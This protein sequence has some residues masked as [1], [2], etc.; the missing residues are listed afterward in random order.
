VLFQHN[1]ESETWR[2]HASTNTSLIKRK[3]FELEFRKMTRFERKS[4]TR[5]QQV[6]AV[7]EHDRSLMEAWIGGE[8]ITVVPTGVDLKQFHPNFEH[9]PTSPTVVFVGAMDWEPNVDAMEFFCNKIW[10]T[11]VAQ[12]PG[13][14]LRI[15]GRSPSERVRRL[16][17]ASVE[18]TGRVP[19]VGLHLREA[20]V[21]VVPLRIGGGTRLKIY[22]AMAAGKAVVS[23]TVGAE[24]LEVHHGQDIVLADEPQSFADAVL[25][26][27]HNENLRRKYEVGAAELANKYDW[28]VIA[29][30]FLQVL[31]SVSSMSHN[32]GGTGRAGGVEEKA[33]AGA[34]VV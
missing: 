11:I 22:E 6:V 15:V 26:L 33:S 18:V 34:P 27:L 24:G 31:E 30:Q 9:K 28:S 8:R 1:V 17:S 3:L 4:V 21:V 13:A 10:P 2:R 16:E 29:D 25:A 12:T 5:F 23:T 7:S 32:A 19:D 14:K 20:T